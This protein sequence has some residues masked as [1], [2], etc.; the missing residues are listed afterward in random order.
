M[1]ILENVN[2]TY[3][4]G[5]PAINGIDLHV[6]NGEF[7]FGPLCPNRSY[8]LQIW[9]DRVKHVKICHVSNPRK[10]TCLKGSKKECPKPECPVIKPCD[11]KEHGCPLLDM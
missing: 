1:I 8:D 9:V 10:T 6:Q 11:E 5:V 4:T 3:T 2:K 7:V